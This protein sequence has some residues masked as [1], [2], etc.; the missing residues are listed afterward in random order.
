MGKLSSKPGT[1]LYLQSFMVR[2]SATRIS[3]LRQPKANRNVGSMS[4]SSER[5]AWLLPYPINK[6]LGYLSKLIII[7]VQQNNLDLSFCCSSLLPVWPDWAIF[8][9]F[10]ARVAKM[11][12]D[13]LGYLERHDFLC[14]TA[15]TT[16]WET[17]WKNWATF[18]S[19][20]RSHCSWLANSLCKSSSRLFNSHLLSKPCFK[21][22][23][24][25][26]LFLFSFSPNK[27]FTPLLSRSLSLSLSLSVLS[28]SHP[29]TNRFQINT[30]TKPQDN[31][32]HQYIAFIH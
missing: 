14:K 19:N 6:K 21:I 4:F 10:L 2:L 8:Y 22:F 11:F 7:I 16:F 12:G 27:Q 15:V 3:V 13:L 31:N 24:K 28:I 25:N 32:K 30:N 29:H 26:I 9:S 18:D 20:M 5:L 17:F 23:C 1:P